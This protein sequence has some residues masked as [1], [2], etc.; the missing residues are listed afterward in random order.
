MRAFIAIDL[1][2]AVR[3]SL[4]RKMDDLRH[5]L[6]HSGLPKSHQ[7]SNIR[8]SRPEAIH[9]TLKFLG[10]TTEAQVDQIISALSTLEPFERFPIEVKGFGFFPRAAR[11]RV[12]W[13]GVEAPPDLIQLAGRIEGTLEGL[14]VAREHRNYNPHLTLARFTNPRPEPTLSAVVEKEKELKLGRFEVR[15]Y[16]LFE[17]KLSPEGPKYR[18]VVQFLQM[19]KALKGLKS[20]RDLTP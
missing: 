6:G 20:H 11:P 5:A 12:F 3:E 2:D 7:D 18:K 9:L 19:A 10:D 4:A 13:A 17:S 16:F 15:D 8:W 14:G 1:P